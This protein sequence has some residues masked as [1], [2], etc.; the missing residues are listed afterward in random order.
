MRRIAEARS[1]AEAEIEAV[2]AEATAAMVERVAGLAIDED[3]ARAAVK[4]ELVR[5]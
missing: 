2:A 1:S 4:Q 3:T 5:G